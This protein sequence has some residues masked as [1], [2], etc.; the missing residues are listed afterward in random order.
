MQSP[1]A[2][3]ETLAYYAK[4]FQR[5]RVDRAHGVAPHK[6]ILLL[7]VMEQ[8]ERGLMSQNR[9]ELSPQLT[10]TFLKYWSHLGSASHHPDISRPFFHMKSGKFWHLVPRL[11][12]ETVLAAKIKLKTMAEVQRAIAYAYVDED[13]FDFWQV[14]K[15]RESL[16]A[17]LVGHWFPGQLAKVKEISK[18]DEFQDPPGY[19]RDAYALY[20]TRLKQD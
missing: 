9:I 4:K 17:V 3:L 5:L 11:G 14:P 8:V 10:Q 7:A 16:L 2:E 1:I 12:F 15:Y 20:M 13:L 18:T 19:L 6:P